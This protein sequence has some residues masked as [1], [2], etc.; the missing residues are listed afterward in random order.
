MISFEEFA[1]GIVQINHRG[2][3]DQMTWQTTYDL[4]DPI[5]KERGKHVYLLFNLS[6]TT[7]LDRAYFSRF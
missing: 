2:V 4:I 1:D 3:W 5:I 7:Q 6:A